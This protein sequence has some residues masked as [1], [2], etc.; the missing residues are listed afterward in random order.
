MEIHIQNLKPNKSFMKITDNIS[1]P[2][3]VTNYPYEQKQ[4]QSYQLSKV[5]LLPNTTDE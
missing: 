4:W 5:S 3:K 2:H 1:K